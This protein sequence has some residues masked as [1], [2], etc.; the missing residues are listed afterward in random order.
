MHV[1]VFLLVFN[2]L[3]SVL[4]DGVRQEWFFVWCMLDGVVE[5]WDMAIMNRNTEPVYT[6]RIALYCVDCW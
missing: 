6:F 3:A 2:K 5:I 1:A 4:V